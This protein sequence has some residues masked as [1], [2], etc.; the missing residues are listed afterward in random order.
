MSTSCSLC[1]HYYSHLQSHHVHL[2]CPNQHLPACDCGRGEELLSIVVVAY[3][4]ERQ[5]V[6]RI[7]CSNLI[8]YIHTTRLGHLYRGY[9]ILYS[10]SYLEQLHR[11]TWCGYP[12]D[13]SPLQPSGNGDRSPTTTTTTILSSLISTGKVAEHANH[14]EV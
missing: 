11:A 7:F 9:P 14:V 10:Y 2:T 4:I 5:A 1:L 13:K 8:L 12:R 6:F 3:S